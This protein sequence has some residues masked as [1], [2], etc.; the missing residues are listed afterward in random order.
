MS[1]FSTNEIMRAHFKN[2][3]NRR[4]QLESVPVKGKKD[5]K[6]RDHIKFDNYDNQYLNP[7]IAVYDIG[8]KCVF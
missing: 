6:L 3:K 2:C 7:I 1:A 8:K 4:T 5:G